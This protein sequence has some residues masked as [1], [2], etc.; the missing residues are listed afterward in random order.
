MKFLKNKP[1]KILSLT[2]LIT[3]LA[4]GCFGGSKG[5]AAPQV[6]LKIWKP[7]V[8]S[9]KFST[10]IQAYRDK[11]PNVQIEYTERNINTY[12]DDLLNALAS[13]Q[14][15]DIFSIN[16]SW[17]PKYYDKIV[18]A[19][20]K[21]LSFT[22]YKNSF[23]DVMV[24][25]FTRQ[26]KVYGTALWVDSLGLYYNK[27]LL[28]TAGIARPAQTWSELSKQVQKLTKQDSNGYFSRS[29]VAM[30]ENANVN[31]SVDIVYLLMLQAGLVPWDA[32][33]LNP[34]FT[35]GIVTGSGTRSPGVEGVT[36]YTSFASP[37]SQN[38]TWNDRSDYSIDAF[39]NGRASYLYSYPYTIATLYQKAPN[40]NYDIAPVPQYSLDNSSVNLANYFGE[41]VNKQSKV[42]DW[43]WDFLK[44]A[45]SKD[46][47]KKYYAVDKEASG[48]KD[49]IEEQIQDPKIGV[50]AHANLTAKSFYKPDQEKLDTIFGNLIDNIVLKGARPAD[51]LNQA[52]SQASTLT[53]TFQ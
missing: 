32:S 40:L 38:Y 30:G 53:R 6:T 16:N 9:E 44:F 51:A 25:D 50:F 31:R 42:S 43:A 14:G 17:L 29:G 22:D 18:A 37:A 2:L 1:K 8:D 12:Q 24:Q 5:P 3:F 52:E 36:F 33:A 34:T 4:A 19:P 13:G 7:F 21:T 10:I 39:A 27:D 45:T 49:I 15:P 48:R 20:E 26:N 47:L 23:V 35:Q 11:R 46:V 41:V 28:G